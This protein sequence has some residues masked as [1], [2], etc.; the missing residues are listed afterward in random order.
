MVK[1]DFGVVGRSPA[2]LRDL[3]E[4]EIFVDA[5]QGDLPLSL[6]QALHCIPQH[7][8][9]ALA[10]EDVEAGLGLWCEWLEVFLGAFTGSELSASPCSAL[11]VLRDIGGDSQQPG[12]EG[13][14]AAKLF[15]VRPCLEEGLLDDVSGGGF[16]SR[17]QPHRGEEDASLMFPH[18]RG[19]HGAIT[20]V[21]LAKKFVVNSLAR[22]L[23]YL[24]HDRRPKG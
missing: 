12:L 7:L 15:S 3:Y 20:G 14:L 18:Q 22:H 17:G 23:I 4:R 8:A 13:G 19:E 11:F 21:D 9:R 24:R 1:A 16:V 2:A 5:E 6:R 10:G